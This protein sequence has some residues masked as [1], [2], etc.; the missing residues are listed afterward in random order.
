MQ[1]VI[2]ISE[3]ERRDIYWS[4]G[5]RVANLIGEYKVITVLPEEHGDLIDSSAVLGYQSCKFR[6]DCSASG[7]ACD[8]CSDNCVEVSDI[9]RAEVIIPANESNIDSGIGKKD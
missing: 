2:D 3:K 1:I 4:N 7:S 9:V 6:G 8:K 5:K